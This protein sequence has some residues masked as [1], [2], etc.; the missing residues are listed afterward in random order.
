MR[1][2]PV[3][4]RSSGEQNGDALSVAM[5]RCG[6]QRGGACCVCCI[7]ESTAGRQSPCTPRM[8]A[9]AC[10]VQGCA[11]VCVDA[12]DVSCANACCYHTVPCSPLPP[13]PSAARWVW[14]LCSQQPAQE[15]GGQRG[16]CAHAR[17]RPTR[18]ALLGEVYPAVSL[19]LTRKR[20]GYA[21]TCTR[22]P[23]ICHP[24]A[25]VGRCSRVWRRGG[26]RLRMPACVQ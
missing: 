23:T 4:R 11:P 19:G 1:G 24:E 15:V 6:Q 5:V 2:G 12:V 13:R 20:A 14:T 17:G 21:V 3:H 25:Q 22:R 16:T 8:T 10:H 9:P 7:H 26:R 18:F